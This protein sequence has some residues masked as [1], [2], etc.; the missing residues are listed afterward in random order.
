M[1]QVKKTKKA[2]GEI[3]TVCPKD[4]ASSCLDA[5]TI[6]V[7]SLQKEQLWSRYDWTPRSRGGGSKCSRIKAAEEKGNG[8]GSHKQESLTAYILFSP[9]FMVIV[10]SSENR[11]ENSCDDVHPDKLAGKKESKSQRH[12]PVMP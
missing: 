3:P 11:S 10:I 5:P 9:I 2:N 12:Q 8:H 7:F 1:N 4:P 6:L